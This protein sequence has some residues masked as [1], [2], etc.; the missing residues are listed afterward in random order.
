MTTT[1]QRPAPARRSGFSLV[2]IVV[3]VGIVATVMV[4]LLGMIPTGLNTVNDA[5]HTMS[6]IRI[7]QQLLGE[8]Q[9]AE[10]EELRD[11]ESGGPYYYDQEGNEVENA[12]S[13][14][15][16]YTAVVELKNPPTLPGGRDQN[17]YLR[18]VV[19]KV[20]HKRGGAVNFSDQ[21]AGD[22]Y[23]QFPGYA[24]KIHSDFEDSNF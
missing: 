4:A 12:S 13:P 9:S 24:V 2:E 20:S 23:V 18:P 15:R 7:A 1:V 10:W 5:A 6:E 21:A 14:G 8:M 17:N 3:A 11:W 22:E 19:V 16:V